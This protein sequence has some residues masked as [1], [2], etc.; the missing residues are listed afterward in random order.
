MGKN[1]EMTATTTNQALLDF[2]DIVAHVFH[3]TL[4]KFYQLE[5]LWADAEQVP[6]ETG[7]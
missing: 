4:R 1:L 3:P 6:L 7:V 5:R 2:V